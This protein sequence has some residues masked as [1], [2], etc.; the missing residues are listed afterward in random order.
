MTKKKSQYHKTTATKPVAKKLGRKVVLKR[1]TCHWYVRCYNNTR[2][3]AFST[4]RKS[5]KYTHF[6][7]L[8]T[9]VDTDILKSWESGI[10][11]RMLQ[12]LQ[13][14]IFYVLRSNTL[15][16]GFSIEDFYILISYL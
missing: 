7:R 14:A 13:N 6:R 2:I 12:I 3:A 1:R 15:D 8:F 5:I 11:E 16:N 4:E 10:Q 9:A